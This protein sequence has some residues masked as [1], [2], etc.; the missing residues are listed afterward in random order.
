M[1]SV[2]LGMKPVWASEVEPFPIRVTST[3]LPNMKHLGSITDIN[4]GEIEP[5]DIIVGGSP[6]FP[7]GTLVLTRE[8]YTPIEDVQVG[9]LVLTHTGR[10]QKVLRVGG[11]RS[12]TITLSG[13]HH[14]GFECTANHPIYSSEMYR[15][16]FASE[17]PSP[18]SRSGVRKIRNIG[19]TPA[20]DM[21][22]KMWACP[23][24][25]L[26]EVEVPPIIQKSSFCTLPPEMDENFWWMVG[27][28][29][30]DG[31]VRSSKR[32]DR[33]DGVTHG[34]IFICCG[35]HKIEGV[36]DKL[37]STG[38]HW[39]ISEF[40]QSLTKFRVSHTGLANWLDTYFGHG[41]S[42]KGIPSFCFT[43][44]EAKRRSL[45]E[46][47]LSSDGHRATP[48]EQRVTTVSKKL[49]L[50]VQLLAETL[51]YST[52]L[53]IA[54]TPDTYVIEG[55]TVNQRD[56]YVVRVGSSTRR[57]SM[58]GE[59]HTWTKVKNIESAQSDTDVFNLEVE[60]DNSY[61]T[62]NV[63][64]HNCQDLSI[65]GSRAGLEEGRRSSLFFEQIRVIK[66]MRIATNGKYPKHGVWE[67]VK[68]A[69]SSNQG[70]DFLSVLQAFASITDDTI[71]IPEPPTKD[72]RIKWPKAGAIVGNGFSVAWRV[73]DAQYWGV[74]QRRERIFLVTSFGDERAGEILF[75]QDRSDRDIA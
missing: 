35:N 30:G 1:A 50:G 19:W 15:T 71:C 10:W 73:L 25:L 70:R 23:H 16:Y 13:Q 17:S 45:M 48:T 66:E 49:A 61:V 41:A 22:G 55:R 3:R 9:D 34:T 46:G 18:N 53:W 14:Y 31:W 32:K 6:C 56:Y 20:E 40:N 59:F 4:G 21:K 33:G 62:E 67:N 39:S 52:S 38:M 65:A 11:K 2:M 43:L 58:N 29:L 63:V 68:G 75:K 57:N 27:R 60:N 5:V 74:P 26:E 64:V 51:G 7:R 24:S 37:T 47:I 54:R 12:S 28:W 36:L 69:F 72:G 44:P 42:N 8:G